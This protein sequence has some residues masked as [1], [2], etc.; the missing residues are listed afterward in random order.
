MLCF[1]PFRMKMHI[2]CHII[3][4]VWDLLFNVNFLHGVTVKRL[5]WVSTETLNSGVKSG[6]D[7]DRLRRLWNWP[8]C[9]LHYDMATTSLWSH[10]VPCGGFNKNI[11]HTLK[12][13]NA[14]S[15]RHGSPWE[16][17]GV[18]P[19]WSRCGLIE[20]LCKWRA[21]RLQKAPSKPRDSCFLLPLNLDMELPASMS[22]CTPPCF[23][24]GG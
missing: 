8:E 6:R 12:Y 21:L 22:I 17:L 3:L 19:F 5:P 24:P 2:L 18:C 4:E 9:I 10:K 16:V 7:C 15:L 23:S 14:W 13:L 11:H 1:F 20:E